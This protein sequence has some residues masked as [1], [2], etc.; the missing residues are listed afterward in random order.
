MSAKHVTRDGLDEVVERFTAAA[1][2][3]VRDIEHQI[4]QLDRRI[5]TYMD[6]GKREV[7][8]LTG[9]LESLRTPAKPAATRRAPARKPAAK[10]PVEKAAKKTAKK[11]AARKPVAKKTARTVTA[12]RAPAK[13][14]AARRAA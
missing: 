3:I 10:P 14:A 9:R 13:K 4:Q 7:E 11:A 5:Q 12:T 1:E 2:R 6:E 8:H